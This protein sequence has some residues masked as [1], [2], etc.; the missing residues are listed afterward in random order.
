[1]QKQAPTFGRVFVMA[2]FTLSCFGLLLFLWLAFGGSIPLKPKGYR[3]K[4][5]FSEATQ[6]ANEAD[7]RISGVPVGKVRTVTLSRDGKNVAL[8]ELDKRYAPIPSDARAILRQK[9]LLGETYIE[10]TPGT[11]TAKPL[12]E[13]GTLPA[14]N[15]SPSVEL[16][17]IFRAFDDKTRQSFQIWQQSL[18]EAVAGRGGDIN[19]ALG[20]LGPFAEDTNTVLKILASQQGAVGRLVSNTGVVFNALSE[21][22]GQLR[23]LITNS[24]RVFQTTAQKNAQLQ[25]TF[26]ALPTF[27]SESTKTL[28]RLNAFA[29]NT[30]PLITQLRPAAR[31]LSPTL[32]D[33]SATAPDLKNLF[34]NLGPLITA[35]KTGFPAAQ[36]T[37]DDLRPLLG[38]LDP[39]LRNLNPVLDFI[40]LYKPELNA[41]FANTVAATQASDVPGTSKSP[42]HYLRTT[43]P[44]NPENLAVYPNRVGSN[45]PN[46]YEF[47]D[48][49]AKLAANLPVYENRQCGN[50]VPTTGV[51]PP[52]LIPPA[53]GSLIGSLVFNSNGG[54]VVPAPKCVKQGAYTFGGHTGDYPHVTALPPG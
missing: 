48:A 45:R 36:K 40:G 10:L 14:A 41:F 32:V 15:V 8:V 53:L 21:R 16:D 39:V 19:T 13:N 7:V 54:G 1:M 3:F 47:P 12:P 34:R 18:A 30:N 2:A 17:E 50:P 28:N 52:S 35:S 37:L 38:Q 26:I 46:P 11:K 29:R 51:L 4:I 5:P 23:S 20:T 27:E 44:V 31:E 25:Q 42:V 24:N 49:F 9:T 43:N 6:L 22:D 33:L